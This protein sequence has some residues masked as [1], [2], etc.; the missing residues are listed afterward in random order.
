M[1]IKIFSRTDTCDIEREVNEF[2]QTV[3]QV[4]DIKI[5]SSDQYADVM[6]IYIE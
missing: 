4:I 3:K 6:V 2:L 1:K 5:S